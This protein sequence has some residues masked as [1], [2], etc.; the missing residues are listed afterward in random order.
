MSLQI[1]EIITNL[2][3]HIKDQ[4]HTHTHRPITLPINVANR[5]NIFLPIIQLMISHRL[6]NKKM[7][8]ILDYIV[9]CI[10]ASHPCITYSLLADIFLSKDNG[11]LRNNAAIPVI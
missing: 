9:V 4:T 2:V 8:F 5:L 11:K 7:Y 3:K 10:T 6:N 1:D